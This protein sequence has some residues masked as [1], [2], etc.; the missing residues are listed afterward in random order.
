MKANR[1][2]LD[3][4]VSSDKENVN[5][6]IIKRVSASNAEKST[7]GP[8]RKSNTKT[9]E[10]V[11]TPTLKKKQPKKDKKKGCEEEEVLIPIDDFVI[12]GIC[13]HKVQAATRALVI[14][15][16]PGVAMTKGMASPFSPLSDVQ[17]YK[18]G[19]RVQAIFRP[20]PNVIDFEKEG[21][22]RRV[23]PKERRNDTLECTWDKQKTKRGNSENSIVAEKKDKEEEEE[24]EKKRSARK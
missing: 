2:K 12:N 9:I 7:E 11:V 4:K 8:T 1:M 16:P 15:N 6:N 14:A 10:A 17:S 5:I 19:T 22:M 24:G 3:K 18:A 23:N 13:A 21:M 20:T